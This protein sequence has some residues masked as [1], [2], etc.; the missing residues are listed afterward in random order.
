MNRVLGDEKVAAR[1]EAMADRIQRHFIT[2]FWVKDHF[3]EYMNPE[4]GLI[5]N[6]GLTD[7]DWAAIATGVARLEHHYLSFY[8]V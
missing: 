8:K 1:Y 7:V 6:H 5:A 3:G 2:R 4:H